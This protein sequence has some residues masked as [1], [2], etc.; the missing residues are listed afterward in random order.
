M[1]AALLIL[2]CCLFSGHADNNGVLQMPER[3]W[4]SPGNSVE[5]NC[6]H[7]KDIN[8]R[9][10]YWFKQVPGEEITLLVFTTVGSE[11]DY[12]K[13]SKDKY[14]AVKDVVESGS[15][16]VKN[17][18][19]GDNALYFCAVKKHCGANTLQH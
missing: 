19:A 2:A 15:L 4:H 9:Q 10:M 7:N 18:D 11:P 16:T 13:F 17:L 6:S 5:M 14:E 12:G 3:L 8:H 1:I